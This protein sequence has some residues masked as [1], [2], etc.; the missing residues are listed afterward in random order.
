MGDISVMFEVSCPPS[1]VTGEI[2]LFWTADRRPLE[3]LGLEEVGGNEGRG[4]GCGG[5]EGEA[6]VL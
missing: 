1:G 6:C 5:K 3:V 4:N 2:A